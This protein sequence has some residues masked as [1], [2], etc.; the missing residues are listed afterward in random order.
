MLPSPPESGPGGRAW[1][2]ALRGASSSRVKESAHPVPHP[3]AHSLLTPT[4]ASAAR[5]RRAAIPPATAP[6]RFTTSTRT[7]AAS[8]PRR[9]QTERTGVV[10]TADQLRRQRKRRT[11]VTSPTHASFLSTA[12]LHQLRMD[13]AEAMQPPPPPPPPPLTARSSAHERLAAVRSRFESDPHLDGLRDAPLPNGSPAVHPQPLNRSALELEAALAAVEAERDAVLAAL[14]VFAPLLPLQSGE[15]GAEE[16]LEGHHSALFQSAVA[17]PAASER[18]LHGADE[19]SSLCGGATFSDAEVQ[20]GHWPFTVAPPI[21]VEVAAGGAMPLDSPLLTPKTTLLTAELDF[22]RT[23]ARALRRALQEE[24]QQQQQQQKQ[25]Q[26]F[27][28]VRGEEVESSGP[29]ASVVA[30]TPPTD[31][32]ADPVRNLAESSLAAAAA[33]VSTTT[34]SSHTEQYQ[35]YDPHRHAPLPKTAPLLIPRDSP[36]SGER[37]AVDGVPAAPNDTTRTPDVAGPGANSPSHTTTTSLASSLSPPRR[38][39]AQPY[40]DVATSTVDMTFLPQSPSSSRSPLNQAPA[41]VS[42]QRLISALLGAGVTSAATAGSASPVTSS[43]NN[44]VGA[45]SLSSPV[46]LPPAAFH[47]S[48]P[49]D[50]SLSPS[51]PVRSSSSETIP[52]GHDATR[53]HSTQPH[54]DDNDL[55]ESSSSVEDFRIFE[56]T[57]ARLGRGASLTVSPHWQPRSSS[58]SA[59]TSSASAPWTRQ[60]QPH[61]PEREG[62]VTELHPHDGARRREEARAAVSSSMTASSLSGPAAAV[63]AAPAAVASSAVPVASGASNYSSSGGGGGGF[64]RGGIIGG[65]GGIIGSGGGIIGSGGGIIGGGGG[66]SGGGG[67]IIGGGGGIIGGAASIRTSS[68]DAPHHLKGDSRGPLS[69]HASMGQNV[70]ARPGP[71]VSTAPFVS[72]YQGGVTGTAAGTTASTP[73]PVPRYYSSNSSLYRYGAVVPAAAAAATPVWAAAAPAAEVAGNHGNSA[74]HSVHTQRPRQS[75]LIDLPGPAP[76]GVEEAVSRQN[77][78]RSIAKAAAAAEGAKAA[79]QRLLL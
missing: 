42:P 29:L 79:A 49:N 66:I 25:Q 67:G 59:T 61:S 38:T 15:D 1:E 64:I 28:V 41:A 20:A 7:A 23:E 22:L 43:F 54:S 30:I 18:P 17:P 34:T 40:G 33:L 51:T 69:I 72:S 77:V 12:L 16:S 35:P 57:P 6:P 73:V 46:A 11:S 50:E 13:E 31:L 74:A 45:D 53:S 48:V 55:A 75:T 60:Q 37:R 26:Q 56:P 27:M 44:H 8:P 24:K 36:P 39:A 32:I 76:R 58:A 21:L 63:G 9:Q 71:F 52:V 5:S 19:S 4:K 78:A 65:G 62:I 68:S 70:F 2:S 47:S 3:P 14:L 10:I